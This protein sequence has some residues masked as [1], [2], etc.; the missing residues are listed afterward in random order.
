MW[1]LKDINYIRNVHTF[2]KVVKTYINVDLA[3]ESERTFSF[4]VGIY[5]QFLF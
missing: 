1:S 2:L 4:L 5:T 3:I